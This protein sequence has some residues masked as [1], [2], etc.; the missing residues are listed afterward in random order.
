MSNRSTRVLSL[1]VAGLAVAMPVWLLLAT[2]L[3]PS[4]SI[5][6]GIEAQLGLPTI[7]GTVT[8]K[9]DPPANTEW[10][11]VFASRTFPPADAVEFSQAWSGWINLEGDTAQYEIQVP[12]FGEY[13]AVA[14][15]WKG[16][17]EPVSLADIIGI[18]GA[19]LAGG[20]SLPVR[21]S[22]TPAAPVAEGVDISADLARVNRGAAVRGRITYRGNWPASTWG[23]ALGVYETR[24][25]PESP[26]DYVF[27]ASALFFPLP[28]KVE[29][30][31]YRL[32]VP[33]GTYRY[34]AVAWLERGAPI[35]D[36]FEIGFH[37]TEPGS[38]MPGYF[39]VAHGDTAR[40]ID[41]T[42]DFG[43]I[44]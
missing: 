3:L 42:A 12:A 15:I 14:A 10:V 39:T 27:E 32:A 21:V 7:R 26:M 35:F 18:H 40:G 4:C 37:E 31:D 38:G 30:Y 2:A 29:V 5:D 19:A 6:H 28:S 25:D 33:P 11:K 34:A 23:V 22:V 36:F 43:R 17:E 16:R 20:L 8:L 24:P 9:G 41:I 44:R 13:A 1:P